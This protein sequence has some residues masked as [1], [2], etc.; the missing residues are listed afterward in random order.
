MGLTSLVQGDGGAIMLDGVSG[1][2]VSGATV[3]SCTAANYGGAIAIAGS[4]VTFVA[5]PRSTMQ[6]CLASFGGCLGVYGLSTV[7][8]EA[9]ALMCWRRY[10]ALPRT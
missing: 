5:A 4:Q 6:S 3:T 9:G 10:I 8:V 2:T 7:T 1:V